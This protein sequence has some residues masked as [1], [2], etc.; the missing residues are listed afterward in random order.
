VEIRHKN[1]K[2]DLL[3]R[4]LL[5]CADREARKGID[6]WIDIGCGEGF[7]LQAAQK[8]GILAHGCDFSDFGIQRFH[9]HLLP[10]FES[11][12]AVEILHRLKA[13]KQEFDFCSSINVLEARD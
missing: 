12:N 6:R 10:S 9:P 7:V 11:G 1:H 5:A 8:A 13:E 4:V 2:A 3:V